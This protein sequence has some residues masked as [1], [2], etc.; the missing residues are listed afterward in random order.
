MR[1]RKGLII[2]KLG[3]LDLVCTKDN[4][5]IWGAQCIVSNEV[6]EDEVWF[7]GTE[8]YYFKLKNLQKEVNEMGRAYKCDDCGA[9]AEEM[10]TVGEFIFRDKSGDRK[11]VIKA[12]FLHPTWMRTGKTKTLCLSCK[13]R[14]LKQAVE[15]LQKERAELK[16]GGKKPRSNS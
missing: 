9:L 12:Q 10:D 11:L 13:I 5:Q 4:R 7:M 2:P 1:R 6:P 3:N 15:R 8:D 14:F 16:K